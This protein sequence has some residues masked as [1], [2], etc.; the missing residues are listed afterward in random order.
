MKKITINPITRLEGPGKIEIFLDKKGNVENAFLQI[1]EFRG[2]EKFCEGRP[3]EEMPR[4]TPRICG[5][6]PTAHHIASAR[7][8]DDLYKVEPTLPGKLVRE[9]LYHLFMFEDHTLHFYY[10]GGPDFIV[11]P[12]APAAQRN[13][14]GV[15]EKVG[16]EVAGKVISIRKEIR[17]IMEMIGGKVI[18]PVPGLPGGVSKHIPE[19]ERENIKK[20]AKEAV[21][22]AKF[23]I[24][25][26]NDIVLKNKEYVGLITGDIF[27][28][29]TYYIGLVD[30]NDQ[31]NYYEGKLRVVDGDGNETE[32]FEV[33]DYLD[34]ISEHTEPFSY[35]KFPFL[36][37][38]G[39]KGF[40]EG[41]DSGVFRSA[42]LARLNVSNGLPTPQAHQ[43]YER[44]YE[45]LGGKPSHH[46]LA[47]HWARVIEILYAAE[48]L[49]EL[50]E[51]PE[52]TSPDV[53]NIPTAEPSVG[54]GVVEAPRGTLIHHYET[55]KNGI[56][57][58]VNLI[59]ATQFNAAGIS[60]SIEKAA[61]G[62]I[63]D[64]KFDEGIL[65]MVEMAFRAYDP[66]MACATHALPG[67]IPLEVNLYDWKKEKVKTISR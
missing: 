49:V 65:N 32:K 31:M 5:V 43:E 7:T 63:K 16:M 54:I 38:V 1:P 42:P 47:F 6:C 37:K 8:L 4:I 52:L 28:H 2:F 15:I 12:T 13:I 21:E 40:K 57:E 30:D 41:K 10:L 34:H 44:M 55:D 64:G 14:L 62:L 48:K 29:N 17:K 11:G 9:L 53:R 18:H 20:V 61:Q 19:E 45:T 59:V 36:K 33:K 56:L 24:Q 25:A 3:A 66:C 58:K 22:F 35:M 51:H 23:T 39:W 27:C 26:F 67:Q 60:M 50:S 46:T